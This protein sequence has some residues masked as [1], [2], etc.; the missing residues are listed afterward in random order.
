MCPQIR[1]PLGAVFHCSDAAQ[2][3]LAKMTA[4]ANRLSTTESKIGD[5]LHELIMSGI[6]SISTI[7]SCSQHQKR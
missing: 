1:N 6:D 3:T 2:E 5:E 7:I 4:L